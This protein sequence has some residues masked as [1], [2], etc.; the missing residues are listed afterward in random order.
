[1]SFKRLIQSL[2]VGDVQLDKLGLLARQHRYTVQRLFRR[3]VQIVHNNHLV[4]GFQEGEGGERAN[5]AGTSV[6]C[7]SGG[8]DS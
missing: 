1:M 8:L 7:I 5:V 2:L 3:V 4:P 6:K